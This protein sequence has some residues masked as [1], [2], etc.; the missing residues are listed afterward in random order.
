M[1]I[2]TVKRK[3]FFVALW[4]LA[5]IAL[6]AGVIV[7][8][9]LWLSRS[10]SAAAGDVTVAVT[11][12]DG[13][14]PWST[15]SG[16]GY[17]TGPDNLTVRTNDF[18]TYK[19]EIRVIPAQTNVTFVMEL[20]R[21]T[22]LASMPAF[23][24]AGSTISPATMPAPVVPVTATSWESLPIQTLTCA[25][26]TRSANSTF[27][28]PVSVRVRPE[29]PN[30]TQLT[31]GSLTAYSA[32][33]T[34][35]APAPTPAAITVSA[36]AQYDI[37]K[38]GTASAPNS[39]YIYT[40]AQNCGGRACRSVSVPILISAPTG[41]KG[42]SPLSSP[43]T[44]TDDLSPPSLYPA[45]YSSDP[46][47]IA[48]GT[49]ALTKY[50][51]QFM[52]CQLSNI[53][54]SP[55]SKINGT[56]NTT[57]NSVRDSGTWS[58]SQPGGPGTPVTVSIA[59]ADT[60][61]YTYPTM[62]IRPDNYPLPTDK[63]YVISG[64]INYMIPVDAII[65]LGVVGA[66]SYGATYSLLTNNQLKDFSPTGIDGANN[67]ETDSTN[68]SRTVNY[69]AANSGFLSTA[70]A[71]IP[72][73]PG[74]TPAISYNSGN[75]MTEGPP[76]SDARQSGNIS[77]MA[78][79][80]VISHIYLSTQTPMTT[81]PISF[82]ACSSWDNS[83]LWLKPDA[84]VRSNDV[85]AHGQRNPSNG[86]GVWLSGA[87]RFDTS[88]QET[89]WPITVLYGGGNVGGSGAASTCGDA[90]SPVGWHSNPADVPG[91]DPTKAAQGVYT[92]VTRARIFMQVPYYAA[93]Y[94]SY[95]SI[96]QVVADNPGPTGTRIPTYTAYKFNFSGANYNDMMTYPWNQSLYNVANHTGFNTGDRL[97]LVEGTVRIAKRVKKATDN[98]F[99]TT[100]ISTTGGD[101]IDYQLSP[102]YTG[103]VSS[104]TSASIR[105]EDCLPAGQSYVIGSGSIEPSIV[106]QS[107]PADAG[108]SCGA[109][110]TY[111][112]WNLSDKVVN[113]AI[114][115][116]TF[117]VT[118]SRTI[119]SGTYTNTTRISSPSD[120][121]STATQ[122]TAS[123]QIQITQPTGIQISKTTLTPLVQ[124]NSLNSTNPNDLQWQLELANIN[125]ASSVQD[126]DIIDV[127]PKNGVGQSSFSGTNYLKAVT[128]NQGSTPTQPV[129][130]LYSADSAVV[131]NPQDPSNVAGTATTAWCSAPNGGTR[132]IGTGACPNG[133]NTVTAFRL[134]RTGQFLANETITA[135]VT[136]TPLGNKPDDV[137]DNRL[138]A[139]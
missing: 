13:T 116:I 96:G 79:Q 71:G 41:G 120:A 26:G 15:T 137:Y 44:F 90:D 4:S 127:L 42:I 75:P 66:N 47:W 82:M 111:M 49:N 67:L 39:G 1:K 36:R 7:G 103:P 92:G 100:I 45:G 64:Y 34:N 80:P 125:S 95:L 30:G 20:P 88:A 136:T 16:A 99:E 32:E 77:A 138:V 69:T 118:V 63:A 106:Q 129:Q 31:L 43:I 86:A 9:S 105:I 133:L 126:I 57:T 91:N 14:A 87:V 135:T 107:V 122:R 119:P 59:N 73:F 29:V 21:G 51:A 101:Q 55:A 128:V 54:N 23:C 134:L 78:G 81:T 76:G 65:D 56:T 132:V 58:C 24:G 3:P 35:P 2:K 18:I 46:D 139:Q 40:V 115:P 94:L 25:V 98:N 123:A 93:G 11:Q 28:Y 22:E 50:G 10:S 97:T 84:Y 12:D 19:P 48:A 121:A 130:I 85:W 27:T 52:G 6:S 108:I 114:V 72:N 74:N 17:D 60:T 112:R 131:P 8:M 37:S 53:S 110:A 61:A 113:A 109:G 33:D 70:Y 68:N 5:G 124:T 89:P 104:G 62:A 83:K 102:S 117:R 38:N